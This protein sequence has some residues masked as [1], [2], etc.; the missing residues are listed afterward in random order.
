CWVGAAGRA[1]G[2]ARLG[3]VVG[4]MVRL[5]SAGGRTVAVD[6]APAD[7]TAL[8][9]SDY[10]AASGT[11][12]F[13]PGETTRTIELRVIGD[14]SPETDETFAV[15]LSL[16]QNATIG[17]GEGVVTIRNDDLPTLGIADAT[18]TEGDAGTVQAVFVVSLS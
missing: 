9:G 15:V 18:V 3:Q 4:V 12:T 16:E 1:E 17:D 11:V 7:R 8:A 5:A 10:A 6:Y 14:V 2:D 13:A